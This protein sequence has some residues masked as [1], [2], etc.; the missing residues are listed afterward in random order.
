MEVLAKKNKDTLIHHL[1]LNSEYVFPQI[2]DKS[3]VVLAFIGVTVLLLVSYILVFNSCTSYLNFHDQLCNL[4]GFR[5][6]IEDT[7]AAYFDY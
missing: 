2:F 1:F 5:N 4:L 3:F 7:D 6:N